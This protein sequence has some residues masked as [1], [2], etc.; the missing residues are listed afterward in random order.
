MAAAVLLYLPLAF[1]AFT[2]FHQHAG[3]LHARDNDIIEQAGVRV[4]HSQRGTVAS[5]A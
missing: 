1:R 2:C 4:G 3:W 5:N